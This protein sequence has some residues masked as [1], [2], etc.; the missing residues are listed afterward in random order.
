LFS[1]TTNF[2]QTTKLTDAKYPEKMMDK[3]NVLITGFENQGGDCFRQKIIEYLSNSGIFHISNSSLIDNN[4]SSL[5][6][7]NAD[8]I[9]SGEVEKFIAGSNVAAGTL[10]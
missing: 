3:K 5:K 7:E 4:N 6:N 8:Y 9:I 1:C 2:K 10:A